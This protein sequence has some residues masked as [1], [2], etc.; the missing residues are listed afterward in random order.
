MVKRISINELPKYSRWPEILLGMIDYPKKT[1]NKEE[2]LREYDSE[3]WGSLRVKISRLPTEDLTISKVDKI[4]LGSENTIFSQQNKLYLSN[5]IYAH[6]LCQKIIYHYVKKYL[7]NSKTIVELGAGY[8]SIILDIA[9]KFSKRLIKFIAA[10]YTKQG[11]YCLNILSKKVFSSKVITCGCDFTSDNIIDEKIPENSLI[12]TSLS[13]TCVP[14]LPNDFLEKIIKLKPSYVIN[15]EP[16]PQ[17]FDNSLLGLLRK[18]YIELNDYNTSL[19][20]ILSEG[21]KKEKIEIV[22]K[23]K[24]IFGENCFLPASFVVWKIKE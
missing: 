8:G 24:N 3:K 7:Y 16:I 13:I 12:F 19:F 10:E 1:K 20:E 5:I 18:K 17:F 21:V 4:F 6:K 23:Q 22:E 14:N 11:Q 15:F 2:I 9:E